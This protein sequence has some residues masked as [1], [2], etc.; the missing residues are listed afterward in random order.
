MHW[1]L[2]TLTELVPACGP[3]GK[4]GQAEGIFALAQ[5]NR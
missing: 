3:S 1:G 5:I 4:G 2:Q